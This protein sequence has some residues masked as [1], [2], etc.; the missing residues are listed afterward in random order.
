MCTRSHVAVAVVVV[1]GKLRSG[2][3]LTC[4]VTRLPGEKLDNKTT[5]TTKPLKSLQNLKNPYNYSHALLI[6]HEG[7]IYS[8]VLAND[9]RTSTTR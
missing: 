2:S 9:L 1:V 7:K 8:F 3:N 4:L 6:R 5:K